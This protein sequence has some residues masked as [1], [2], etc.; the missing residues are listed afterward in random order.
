MANLEN[1]NICYKFKRIYNK[2]IEK[3]TDGLQITNEE[4]HMTQV[5][6]CQ[7]PSCHICGTGS[8]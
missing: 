3:K 8:G 5:G 1:K 6:E 7:T 2:N 4:F